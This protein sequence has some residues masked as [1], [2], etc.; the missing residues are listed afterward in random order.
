MKY[1][2]DQLS[3]A[4]HHL[5]E[6]VEKFAIAIIHPQ[7]DYY[8]DLADNHFRRAAE[9]LELVLVPEA[10]VKELLDQDTFYEAL[11]NVHDM[12]TGLQEFAAAAAKRM[13]EILEQ[14]DE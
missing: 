9:V 4:H 14:G 6:A 11:Y 10:K 13:Q 3:I 8:I 7:P 1:N 12:D 2:Y 5:R